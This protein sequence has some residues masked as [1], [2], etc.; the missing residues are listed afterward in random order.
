MYVCKHVCTLCV[1][2]LM[3]CMYVSMH[4]DNDM[5]TIIQHAGRM[6]L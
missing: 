3:Y 4:M 5:Y 2:E 1:V 6:F